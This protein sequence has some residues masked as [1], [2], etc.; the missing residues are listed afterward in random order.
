MNIELFPLDK[1]MI[2]GIAVR[3]GMDRSSV[4]A[5]IG[6]GQRIKNRDY[7]FGSE[8]AVYYDEDQRVEF[9]EFL[10]G[11]DGVLQPVIYGVSAFETSADELTELLTQKNDGDINDSE[12]GYSYGFLNISVGVYRERI[13]SDVEDMI[14]DAE[15][16][17]EPLD[18]DETAEEYR[19][20][21]H[22]ATIGI[23]V[24]GYYR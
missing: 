14:E 24:E 3:L 5:A 18:D 7:Y 21:D 4:E 10:G 13:P 19:K 22:W 8:M 12:R 16:D 23:G 15:E 2:D 6:K 1:V 9:I 17:G 20:A 11:I